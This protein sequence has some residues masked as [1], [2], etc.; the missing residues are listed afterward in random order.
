M[1]MLGHIIIILSTSL[2]LFTEIVCFNYHLQVGVT[3]YLQPVI[4]K[5]LSSHPLFF[6]FF[7]T[8]CMLILLMI[9]IV[10]SL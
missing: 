8:F 3:S 4:K 2:L 10:E 7:V 9:V 5:I 6:S 1:V